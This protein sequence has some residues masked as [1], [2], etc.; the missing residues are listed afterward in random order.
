MKTTEIASLKNASLLLSLPAELREQI[1]E[2]VVTE[3]HEVQIALGCGKWHP[4]FLRPQLAA[5]NRQLRNE[6]LP[7]YYQKNTFR[8]SRPR[9]I[10]WKVSK[11]WIEATGDWIHCIRK[12]QLFHCSRHRTYV[13]INVPATETPTCKILSALSGRPCTPTDLTF[14]SV[15]RFFTQM[16]EQGEIEMLFYPGGNTAPGP[17]DYTNLVEMMAAESWCDECW[18]EKKSELDTSSFSYRL[19]PIPE[20]R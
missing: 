7:L 13:E 8:I 4:R 9:D 3:A 2:H 18:P 10:A 1:F 19:F 5:V 17:S 16:Q 20:G 14:C 6:V 11:G 12:L 15:S